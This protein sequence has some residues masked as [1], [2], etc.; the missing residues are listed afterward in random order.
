MQF[1][2]L[3]PKVVCMCCT[4]IN[5]TENIKA[6]GTTWYLARNFSLWQF[7]YI[8][9]TTVTVTLWHIW[10]RW[11]V[12]HFENI[13]NLCSLLEIP[14]VINCICFLKVPLSL[15]ISLWPDHL[16]AWFLPLLIIWHLF[17]PQWTWKQL[18]PVLFTPKIIAPCAIVRVLYMHECC[19]HMFATGTV[20]G[21]HVFW[22]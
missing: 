1:E 10:I 13:P 15:S 7:I 18:L 21:K 9:S 17:S 3:S 12:V 16:T 6:A 20:K 14:W 19:I 2:D 11:S 5:K 8:Q 22:M 4:Q